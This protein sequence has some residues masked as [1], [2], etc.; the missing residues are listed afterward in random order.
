MPVMEATL[1]CEMPYSLN[2]GETLIAPAEASEYHQ[3]ISFFNCRLIELTDGTL[4]L[5]EDWLGFI[6]QV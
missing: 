3:I 2:C 4:N 6:E 1:A 5:M